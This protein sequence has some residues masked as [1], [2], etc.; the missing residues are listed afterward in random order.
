M[1]GVVEGIPEGNLRFLML[2]RDRPRAARVMQA[3]MGLVVRFA[4]G[5]VLASMMAALPDPDRAA[6]ADA[7]VQQA[8]LRMVRESGR[9]G[10]RGPQ[11]DSALMVSPWGFDP[12]EIRMPVSIWKGKQDRNAPLAMA[13]HLDR[14][15]PQSR[16]TVFPDDGHISVV[17]RHADAIF[18]AIRAEHDRV[19]AGRSVDAGR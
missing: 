10:V 12:A 7:D 3:A 2:S 11:L 4:P 5:R 1:P 18:G 9:Q 15:I 16:L 14:A 6:V 17:T 8:F 13:E 19:V